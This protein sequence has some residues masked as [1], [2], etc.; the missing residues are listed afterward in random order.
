MLGA[1]AQSGGA[2]G[3]GLAPDLAVIFDLA[4][5]LGLGE[6][7]FGGDIEQ[8]WRYHLEP[9]GLTLEE[10]RAHPV[11]AKAAVTNHY[12]KYASVDPQTGRP[13]GFATPS[14]KLELYS[15]R[16][17]DAGYDPLPCHDEPAESPLR[18]TDGTRPLILT[19]FR[20]VQFVNEQHRNIPRL[21]NE[22]REPVIEINSDT[23]AGLDVGDG[24]WVT[25]E[26]AAAKIK[27]RAKFNDH[28]HPKVVCAHYGWWQACRELDLP[29][30]DPLTHEGANG[31]LLI[32]NDHIDPIS[33]S[34]PHRS[35]MCRVSKAA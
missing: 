7:F 18:A 17:A 34:V 25:V 10:L 4:C 27:L 8:A 22:V 1:D 33:A 32:R 21:R 24:E 31:N 14:R 19:W 9:S 30:Y 12:R 23:A 6:H 20:T 2:T 16:F 13:R 26:T 28:L 35:S 5:R 29:A 15:T 3:G 11:G